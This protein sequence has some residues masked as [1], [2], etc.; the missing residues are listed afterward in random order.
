MMARDRTMVVLDAGEARFQLRAVALIRRNGH[1]LV[2]RATRDAYW[3]LPG[4]RVE[5]GEP[6]AQAL[7]REIREE[8]DSAAEIGQLAFVIENFFEMDGRSVHGLGLYFDIA[9]D[10]GFPFHLDEVVHRVRDGDYDLEFRWIPIEAEAL[11]RFDLKPSALH[12]L[13]TAQHAG[14]VHAVHRDGV[15]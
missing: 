3:A 9:I 10:H 15:K 6:A 13:L 4:G 1:I 8:L 11:V 14:T 7:V 5:M 12:D 2:Q